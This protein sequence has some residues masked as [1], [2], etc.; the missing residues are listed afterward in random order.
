MCIRDRFNEGEPLTIADGARTVSVGAHNW[1]VL[2]SG[3]PH[4]VEVEESMI[5]LG[6]RRLAAGG[7]RVE[8]TGAL[9]VGALLQLPLSERQGLRLGC[10]LSGGNVDEEVYQRLL[11]GR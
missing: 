6:L 3:M 2:R 11:Y 8:P 10:V 5:G 4:I 7:I 9:A 1:E